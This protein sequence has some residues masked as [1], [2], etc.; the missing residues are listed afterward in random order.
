[1]GLAQVGVNCL[2]VSS[3]NSRSQVMSLEPSHIHVYKFFKPQVGLFVSLA[4]AVHHGQTCLASQGQ[5]IWTRTSPALGDD[6][7][8]SMCLMFS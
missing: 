1:M 5:P 7:C 6:F 3:G 8:P 2:G 4:W